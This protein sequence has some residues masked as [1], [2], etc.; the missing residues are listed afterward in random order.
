MVIV[1]VVLFVLALAVGGVAV[2]GLIGKLPRNR[3][4]GV[5]TPDTLRSEESF[6][7]A[8]KVAGPTMAAAAGLLVIG[9]IAALTMSVAMGLGIA[10]V[11]VVAA[12]FT[13]GAGGAIGARAAAAMPEPSG[14]GNDCNCG[15]TDSAVDQ[16]PVA[17]AAASA[18][19]AAS[20]CGE[21]SCGACSLKGAC[22]PAK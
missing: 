21:S 10:L 5:R 4:A 20:E 9:G 6:G 13:A 16:T 12:L 22:L 19:E 15:H 3:W 1:A 18:K 14:C 17:K 8:N 7:L 11:A 2:A